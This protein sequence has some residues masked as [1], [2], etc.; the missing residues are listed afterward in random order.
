MYFYTFLKIDKL[1][2]IIYIYKNITEKG[3]TYN[4]LKSLN[5]IYF[6]YVTNEVSMY[7]CKRQLNTVQVENDQAC[8][9][10]QKSLMKLFKTL[11][12]E[13]NDLINLL[14]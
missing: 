9:Y 3:E 8:Y 13:S 14:N 5:I 2:D 4:Y 12:F 7:L 10:N 11:A 6:T 1:Y